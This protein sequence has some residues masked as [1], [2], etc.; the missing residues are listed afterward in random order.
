VPSMAMRPGSSPRIDALGR[1]YQ[2]TAAYMLRA[3]DL[4]QRAR[5][6]VGCRSAQMEEQLP[7]LEASETE[8]VVQSIEEGINEVPR[9]EPPPEER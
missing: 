3:V 1:A 9:G 7:R 4:E 8:D 5:L 2:R 6:V